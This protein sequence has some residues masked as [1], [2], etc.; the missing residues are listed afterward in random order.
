MTESQN[1]PTITDGGFRRHFRYHWYAAAKRAKRAAVFRVGWHLVPIRRN[2]WVR[3]RYRPAGPGRR[4][5]PQAAGQVGS[6]YLWYE[7]TPQPSVKITNIGATPGRRDLRPD[8]RPDLRLGADDRHAQPRQRDR[9]HR[10]HVLGAPAR[11]RH[12]AGR[13]LFRVGRVQRRS[14]TRCSRC[15]ATSG[16]SSSTT[17]WPAQRRTRFSTSPPPRT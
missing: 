8:L 10:G 17:R 6:T 9:W 12:R 5:Y 15:R 7:W 4:R 11:H 14:A 2:C 13:Q 1:D 16:W 3:E